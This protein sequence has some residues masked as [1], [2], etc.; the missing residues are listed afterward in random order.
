VEKLPAEVLGAAFR[1]HAAV[2]AERVRALHAQQRA[3]FAEFVVGGLLGEEATVVPDPGA[4]WDIEWNH[5][6]A[7]VRIQVKCSGEQRPRAPTR[8]TPAVWSIRQ[9]S[10]GWDPQE[11]CRIG[12]GHHCE[13]FVLARHEGNN[14]EAGWRFLVLPTA[15]ITV[16]GL[17]DEESILELGAIACAPAELSRAVAM[18][19]GV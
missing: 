13:V 10:S 19:A 17:F 15:S 6:G 16:D 1:M 2:Q 4:A 5:A 7:I 8:R 3:V 14:I 12:P 11:R 18:A 9:P